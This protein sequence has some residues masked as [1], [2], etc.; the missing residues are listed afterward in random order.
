MLNLFTAR[1]RCFFFAITNII[2]NKILLRILS[3]DGRVMGSAGGHGPKMV[4]KHWVSIVTVRR[5][6]CI[7]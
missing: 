2:L 4:E 5:I 7:T 1:L 6:Y 3:K